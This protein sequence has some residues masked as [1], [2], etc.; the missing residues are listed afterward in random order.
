MTRQIYFIPYKNKPVPNNLE[1]LDTSV[2][3]IDR[4]NTFNYLGVIIDEKL[5]W[6]EQAENVCK[7]L[8]QFYGIFR[9]IKYYVSRK[10]AR[11]LYYACVFSRIRYGIEVFGVCSKESLEKKQVM[12]NK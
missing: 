8:L 3:N 6:H 9:Q 7:S 1:T 4:V 10:I 11:Q 12:Q 5:N 2:M